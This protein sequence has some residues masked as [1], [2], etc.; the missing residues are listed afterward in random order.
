MDT[1]SKEVQVL[2][3]AINDYCGHVDY[4]AV[5][6]QLF[7]EERTMKDMKDKEKWF[8]GEIERIKKHEFF[9]A[10]ARL[11]R[12]YTGKQQAENLKKH[13]KHIK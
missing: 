5:V 3:D 11:L 13:I 7:E 2:L 9:T 8:A 4:P 1:E 10:T 12:S 6:E